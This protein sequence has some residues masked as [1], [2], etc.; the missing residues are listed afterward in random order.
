MSWV[1]LVVLQK[2]RS[3][4][5]TNDIF[6]FARQKSFNMPRRKQMVPKKHGKL[7]WKFFQIA[8]DLERKYTKRCASKNCLWRRFMCAWGQIY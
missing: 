2:N 7:V 3:L 5:E 1:K 6:I 4:F 8:A